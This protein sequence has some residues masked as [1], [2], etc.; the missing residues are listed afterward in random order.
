MTPAVPLNYLAVLACGVSAM[1]LGSLWY[2]PFFGK[3]WMKIMGISMPDKMSAKVKNEMMRS[4]SLMFIGS[5]VTAG[6]LAHVLVFASTYTKTSG[7]EA[8]LSAGFWSW[9]GFVAPM[10]MGSV[11]WE[12]KPWTLWYINAGYWLVLLCLMGVILS[13]WK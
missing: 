8:G 9:L 12:K 1:V 3:P 10:S 2:G 6:V 7:I 5:L 13:L 4:Y 11:L